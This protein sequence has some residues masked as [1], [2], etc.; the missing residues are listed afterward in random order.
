MINKVIKTEIE[1]NAALDELDKLMDLDPDLGTP[2]SDTLDLLTLLIGDYESKEYQIDLPDPID[3]IEFRMEQQGLTNR[4]LIP[5]LGSRSKVSEILGRKRPLTLSMIRALHQGFEI[6]A[7]VLL[8]EQNILEGEPIAWN[9]F[10]IKEMVKRGWIQANIQD[11]NSQAETLV[12]Q[13]FAPLK[14]PVVQAILYRKTHHVR[15]VRKVDEYAL[16]AWSARVMLKAIEE[17]IESVYTPGTVTLEFMRELTKLSKFEDGPLKAREVLRNNG[18][19]LIIE[20]HMQRTHLD[21]AAI[22]EYREKPIIGLTLR[23]DRIDNFWFC[24]MH[25]LAH[26]S[27]HLDNDHTVFFDDLDLEG[28]PDLKEQ[29][30]DELAGEALI[31]NKEWNKSAASRL[32]SPVAAQSLAKKLEIHPAIVAGRMRHEFKAFRLLNNLV[33]HRQVRILFPEI[34]WGN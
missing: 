32:R 14:R 21:G 15:S 4:D 10:P 30:A 18:I 8:Q 2:V 7:K 19:N 34:Q 25:E 5:F 11:V 16:I 12:K 17:P 31:P 13:F 20:P 6:P 22:M 28:Q 24:L 3:A 27:L 33:G 23:Y 29:D 26:V 1:Y 9:R